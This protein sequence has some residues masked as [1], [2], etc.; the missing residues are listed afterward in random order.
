[1]LGEVLGS[2]VSGRPIWR[3]SLRHCVDAEGANETKLQGMREMHV[4]VENFIDWGSKAKV[5]EEQFRYMTEL[6]HDALQTPKLN[7]G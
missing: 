4:K 7:N 1:M 5:R 6:C 2:M 3:G